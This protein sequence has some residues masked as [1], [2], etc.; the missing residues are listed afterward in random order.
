MKSPKFSAFGILFLWLFPLPALASGVVIN[1]IAWMGTLP[2]E[3]E[4]SQAAANNEWLELFNSSSS[5]VSLEG[6]KLISEDGAPNITLHGTL[7]AG[8]YFLL[9]RANDDVLPTITADL[10]YPYKD[11]S[12]SNSGERLYL[13]DSGGAVVDEVNSSGGWLAGDN[14]TKYTMQKTSSGWITATSTPK[15]AN[16]SSSTPSAEKVSTDSGNNPASENYEYTIPLSALRYPQ[17]KA[18]A[19]EDKTVMVGSETEFIGNA[20]GLKNEPMPSARF[21]WN[22][23]DGETAEG[24]ATVHIFKALG[25]YIVGLYVSSGEYAASDYANMEVIPN[26]ISLKSVVV[27]EEGYISLTNPA[28][29]N[30]DIG[31]WI[32]EDE[33]GNSFAIPAKTQIRAGGTMSLANTVTNLL[34]ASSSNLLTVRYANHK[35]IF[36]WRREEASSSE[37]ETT[38]ETI[39]PMENNLALETEIINNSGSSQEIVKEIKTEKLATGTP[40]TNYAALVETPVA[41]SGGGKSSNFLFLASV[42]SLGGAAVYFVGR[43]FFNV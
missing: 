4:S 11:N 34:L 10:I 18:Y 6:W 23:G 9:E 24:R 43:K 1:E 26:K 31:G 38:S 12:L 36:N 27:G 8:G 2:K 30:L 17:I 39:P 20:F 21:W 37:E 35:T 32:L 41:K 15:A 19:G 22:F 28:S 14:T 29:A 13:K 5:S 33:S 3:G 40:K 16:P 7:A 25:Q 42:F